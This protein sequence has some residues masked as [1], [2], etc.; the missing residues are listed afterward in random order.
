MNDYELALKD[1]Q[2][3]NDI[4]PNDKNIENLLKQT[5]LRFDEYKKTLGKSLK[6][7]F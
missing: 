3:A 7:L 5:K 2:L 6:N 1:L 4:Q